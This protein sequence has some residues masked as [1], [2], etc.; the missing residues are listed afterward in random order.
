[1]RKLMVALLLCMMC[2]AVWAQ[3][4]TST[5]DGTVRDPQGALVAGA[6]VS[7]SSVATDETRDITT[8]PEGHYGFTNLTPGEYNVSV[9]APGFAKSEHKAVRL[10][11]GHNVTLDV[12]LSL[13]KVG[14]TVTV[15]GGETQIQLTQSEVQGTVEA[16]TVQ[17]IPLNG[18]NFLELAYLI[19]GNRPA[20]NYDP[21]KTNTLEVSSAGQ[22]GRGGNI[23]VDGADNNDEVVGGTLTNFPEDGIQE[24]Q[25]A[26]NKYTAEVGR[27]ASSI[28]NIVTKSG[29]NALHGSAFEFFR[30]KVLQGLPATFDRSQPTPHFD[31][32]QTGGSIGG[33]IVKDKAFWFVSSEYRNQG[34][35]VPVGFRDLATDSV[36]G[37]S[38]PAFLHDFLLTSRADWNISGKDKLGV[39]YSFERSLDVNNGSLRKPEGTAANRQQSLNRYHSVVADWTRVVSPTQVNAF[40]FHVDTFLNNIPAFSPNT[41]VTNPA[42]LAAGHEIRFPT[43]QDGANFRIPQQTP[44]NR[45]EFRDTYSWTMGGHTVRFGA[46]WQNFGAGILFDLF[47]SGSVFTT[48][49]FAQDAC[50]QAGVPIILCDHNGDGVVDDRDLPVALTIASAAPVRP[51]TAA[52]ERNTY[53][54]TFVQDD[55]RIAHN[56]TLNLGVR[57]EADLN[58]LG[59]TNHSTGC[60]SLANASPTCEFIRNILGPHNSSAK[61]KN[62]SPRVGFAWD[63]FS[64]GRTVIRGGYGIYYDRVVL[65][66]PL[67]EELLNGR[68]LPLS[69]LGPSTCNGGKSCDAPGAI[70]DPGTPTLANP[71]AGAPSPLGIGVNVVDNRAATPYVQQFTFGV[72]QQVGQN[73]V[74]AADVIHNFGQRFL[75][76]R[77]LRSAPGVNSPFLTCPNGVDPCQAT[78]PATGQLASA[79][80]G[81]AAPVSC[82][83]VTDVHSAAKTWYDGLLVTLQKRPSAIR[84]DWRWGFNVNYTLSKTFNFANDD[85]IP[86]NGSEDAVNLGFHTNNLRL[87]KGYSPTD[88]RHRFVFFGI[89]NMPWQISVSP[90]WTW[91]SHVPMDSLVPGLSSR[92][93]NIPRDALGEQI[94]NGAALNAAI[95]AYN[96]LPACPSAFTPGSPV[97]CHSGGTLAL[98]SPNLKF[99]DDFN[100]WDMRITKTFTITERQNVQFISEVF[101]LF[102]ITNIRGV[103]N[104]NYSGFNN[105]ITSSSFNRPI[106]TAGQFFGSG[107]PRAFQFALRYVF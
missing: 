55:W 34:F 10:E 67:L 101:N 66:V 81:K 46:E 30:H 28:I 58:T 98:V 72:Q 32:E 23:T 91:S 15:T 18:R 50:L 57:W 102:N 48:E 53:V 86:F 51:P 59:E 25:I 88:E 99:G 104:T 41:A 106:S 39:R 68:D 37:S 16:A 89:F 80:F 27:S 21:T 64:H 85:Q 26:T 82:T 96:A 79:C 17:N 45:Y 103:N 87:E 52:Q 105:D 54:G 71:L 100:S 60:P 95:T 2:P 83:T 11:V 40:L 3:L 43:L 61:Y 75:I 7:L 84:G 73:W 14:E 44:L 12:P 69:V 93:P 6:K 94:P 63:P 5:L 56:L 70:F 36:V 47:G 29:T 62:F 107:G 35:A 90:I 92:L 1:M 42:G 9:S 13:A 65:E 19:P 49:T 24:F 33:P 20:T 8:G 31:R 22:F 76:G 78:D 77:D 38:A 97:P 4:P 74:V